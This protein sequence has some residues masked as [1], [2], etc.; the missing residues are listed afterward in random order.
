MIDEPI[1]SLEQDIGDRR[2]QQILE[3]GLPLSVLIGTTLSLLAEALS[4]ELSVKFTGL[5]L[6][7]APFCAWGLSKHYRYFAIVITYF[8]FA[9][10]VFLSFRSAYMFSL[11]S[12]PAALAALLWSTRC[13]VAVALV[14]TASM[15]AFSRLQGPVS[16][17][18][19]FVSLL[20]LW[21][22]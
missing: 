8:L 12:L 10:F 14:G 17:G 6:V 19:I 13:G 5:F 16:F 9:L 15:F 4:M 21:G 22:V 11:L 1:A 20:L 3:L 7:L 18:A 2:Q